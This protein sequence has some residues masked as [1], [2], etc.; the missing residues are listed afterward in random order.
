MLAPKIA[1]TF[2]GGVEAATTSQRAEYPGTPSV[3]NSYRSTSL[4]AFVEAGGQY[5]VADHFAIGLA[6]RLTGSHL[7]SR[8][9]GATHGFDVETS[10]LPIRATLYF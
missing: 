3:V 9:G 5:M 6:Y 2:G 4:G 8:N 7:S 1:S 10:F